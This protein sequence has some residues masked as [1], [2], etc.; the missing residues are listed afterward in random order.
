[1]H[2]FVGA[3]AC[4]AFM[5]LAIAAAATVGAAAIFGRRDMVGS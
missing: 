1:V 2:C 4:E 5:M 3:C